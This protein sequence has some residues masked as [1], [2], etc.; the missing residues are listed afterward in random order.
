MKAI[1]ISFPFRISPTT[2]GI[3]TAKWDDESGYGDITLIRQSIFQIIGTRFGERMVEKTFGTDLVGFVF[4][5]LDVV[6]R[7]QVMHAALKALATWEPRI[8]VRGIDFYE[9][10]EDG[11]FLMKITY[12]VLRTN[13][14]DTVSVP[15]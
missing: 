9:A 4:D 3:Q 6:L 8:Q 10:Q 14:Q 7:Q 2:G 15:I 12:Q 11:V 5:P 1:G 13:T